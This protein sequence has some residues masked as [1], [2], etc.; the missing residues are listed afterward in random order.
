MAEPQTIDNNFTGKA[1]SKAPPPE[2]AFPDKEHTI[3]YALHIQGKA[4]YQ[5]AEPWN[6]GCLRALALMRLYRQ[7]EYRCTDELLQVTLKA[8]KSALNRAQPDIVEAS[9]LLTDLQERTQWISEPEIA[10][11]IAATT[12]FTA[13]EDPYGYDEN[14]V[15]Q[16]AEAWAANPDIDGFFLRLPLSEYV[17]WPA[18]FK[19]STP[20]YLAE[21][22]MKET[23]MLRRVSQM[24]SEEY[25][26][27]S[28]RAWLQ[29]RLAALQSTMQQSVWGLK[30][31]LNSLTTAEPKPSNKNNA[32]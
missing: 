3:T 9:R 12:Y 14:H 10:L 27:E 30:N 23:R 20:L 32:S 16:K 15:N 26:D 1:P 4:H 29:S 21:V 18:F 19:I 25:A 11:K 2:Q 5:F 24:L 8:I 7:L 6:L 13:E 22:R 31:S 17:D 28:D